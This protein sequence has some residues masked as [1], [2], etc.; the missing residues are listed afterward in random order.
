MK[1]HTAVPL[2]VV[3]LVI[4]HGSQVQI[5]EPIQSDMP[6]RESRWTGTLTYNVKY[7]GITGFSERHVTAT[8]TDALPTL[9]RN[10]DTPNHNFTDDKGRGSVTYHGEEIV[11]GIKI[12]ITDCSGNGQAELRE[13]VVDETDKI[14][15][16]NAIG[17]GCTGTTTYLLDNGRTETYGPEFTDIEI[18]DQPL[19][20]NKNHLA[21]TM[22]E[23]IDLPAGTGTVTKTTTWSLQRSMNEHELIVIPENYDS[24]LPEPGK[25]EL[26]TGNSMKISMKLNGK[27]GRPPTL[28]VKT[29]EL[30]L[31][32]TSAEPGITLNAPLVPLTTFPDL[33]FLPEANVLIG[34]NFQFASV[35]CNNGTTGEATIGSFDGG[36]YTTLTVTA[37]LSDNSRIEGHLLISGGQTEIPVP[38]RSPNSNIGIA[39]LTAHNNPGDSDDDESSP[40]NGNDGDGL[41]AYEEYRGVLSQ[42]AF[43]RL[44]PRKKEL[45]IAGKRAELTEFSGGFSLF[46]SATGFSVIRF[47]EQEIGADRRLNKN[48]ATA[49]IYDQYALKLK[50][51]SI[52]EGDPAKAYGG[53]GIP[54][55]VT[56]LAVYM[57]SIDQYFQDWE[58]EARAQN[59][60]L[61]WSKKELINVIVAHELSHGVNARHHGDANNSPP[62]TIDSTRT[63][64]RIYSYNGTEIRQRPYTIDGRIGTAGNKQ[65]GD[66][67]CIVA[68]NPYCDWVIIDNVNSVSFYQVPITPLAGKMC[69]TATG[70]GIN[71]NPPEP[72][73]PISFFG[74]ALYGNCL[75]QLK[76]KN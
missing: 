53:P 24:W 26:T 34:E 46:E 9:W 21:G 7:K 29:F 68:T 5:K 70:T 75:G 60:Q 12:L 38:K 56:K 6:G 58:R 72:G 11:K 10:D 16:I 57:A 35:K 48:A 73:Q 19:G 61:P 32:N 8:F 30:R 37:V 64:V 50:K 63:R 2:F 40:G 71:K 43:H 36:G 17:P 52:P 59:T 23:T 44:D 39:W 15:H 55:V 66:L 25:N 22:T 67:S 41:S 74:D 28:K 1:K 49:H 42:G 62:I 33:R 13:V 51:E 4:S 3:M 14:Y 76:L 69:S 65:S 18:L 54:K 20:A 45:G 27:N 31:S 47:D